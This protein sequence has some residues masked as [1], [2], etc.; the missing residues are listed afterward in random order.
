MKTIMPKEEDTLTDQTL[1]EKPLIYFKKQQQ[2][3]SR[4]KNKEKNTE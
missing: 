4:V 1:S 2:K 3:L